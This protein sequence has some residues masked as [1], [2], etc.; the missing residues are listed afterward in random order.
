MKTTE[1]ISLGGYAFTIETDAYNELDTYL[2][3]VRKAFSTDP[4]ADEIIADIEER[5][6]EL[7]KEQTV[8]GMVVSLPM[9][10]E[11]KKRIGNPAELAQD[12]AE[13]PEDQPDAQKAEENPQKKQ[14]KKNW[15]SKRLYRDIDNRVFGGVCSGIGAYFGIDYVIIRIIFLILFLIGIP[16]IDEG[17]YVLFSLGVYICLWIAMPAA[18]TDGQKR[19][20]HGRPTDLKGYKG[21]DFDFEREVKEAAQSPA[22]RTL[23]RAGGVFLGILLLSIGL[24]GLLG[25][26]FIPKMPE[27]IGNHLQDHIMRWGA[28]DAE[29]QLMADLLGGTTF[30]GLVLVMLGIGCI[31]MVYGGVML[32]FDLKSP[33]WKPGLVIF[34]SWIISIFVII[35]YVIKI[36]ADAL[37]GLIS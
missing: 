1:N 17:P 10:R 34:I 32:L 24:S 31:G 3:E 18:R 7:L 27:V 30:W 9:I 23:K 15:K 21:K 35:A 33:S 8:P 16:G 25:G 13:R 20:L 28:L 6:A 22:G 12:E 37:P 5:I 29:E 26:F 19:E 4:N 11:I 14:E 2:D 36:V